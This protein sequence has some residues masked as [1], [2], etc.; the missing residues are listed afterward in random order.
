MSARF[1]R[2][3]GVSALG[4]AA[5]MLCVPVSTQAPPAVA[6]QTSTSAPAVVQRA[7]LTASWSTLVAELGQDG[8]R[9]RGSLRQG[10]SRR[11]LL[12]VRR[13][14][15]WVV[16]ART[17]TRHGRYRVAVPTSTY[18]IFT[19]RVAA[20]VTDRQ[21]QEG[22]RRAVSAR[23]TFRVVRPP[24]AE[25]PTPLPP[26]LPS[27]ALGDPD[28][29]T[30]ISSTHARWD[31][32]ST[33]TYRVNT[34]YGP[35]TALADT[36]GAVARIEEATGLDLVYVGPT[37]V[38]PQD[39]AAKGYPADTRLVI[40]WASRS[41][42]QM[43]PADDVAGVGGPMGWGGTTEED[44]TD[45]VAWRRG[46]VV[47]NSAFN[48]L[49]PG[50]GTGTTLGKLLMHEIGH[51][52]G[53]GHA[54]GQTQVM[55]PTLMREQPSAWGAGDL[56]G[57]RSLGAEQGCIY[58]SDGSAPSYRRTGVSVVSAAVVDRRQ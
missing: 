53:L 3:A 21:R 56:T 43:I 49:P 20:P 11:V 30:Y 50:F 25:S 42:S 4:V 55:Y 27:T 57:L 5:A 35:A 23:T 2:L 44:G 32:C 52:V 51:V 24:G 40:A 26:P 39:S 12:Q 19:Y 15:R 41:Q 58:E 38:I 54:S 29:F 16:R 34:T 6:V 18:G 31:P 1:S 13:D 28:D 22:L 7:A 10:G 48:W 17:S 47:L 46:T 37:D 14:D 45:V 9:V 36:H 33:I 8:V